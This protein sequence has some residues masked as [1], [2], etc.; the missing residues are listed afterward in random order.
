MRVAILNSS[1]GFGHI[2]AAEAVEETLRERVP[3]VAVEYIDFWS[4]MDDR[5][6]G[7]VRE[8]Y[9]S[10]VTHEP[11][12][13]DHL[14]RF[15]RRQWREFFRSAD[16]PPALAQLFDRAIKRW[17]P[18]SRGFPARGD[19]LDQT[20]LLNMLDTFG[21]AAPAPANLVRRGLV[22]WMHRLLVA[23]LKRQLQRI[24]P[25]LIVATQMMPASLLAAL[26]RRRERDAAPAIGVLTDYGVHDFWLNSN[27]DHYCVATKSMAAELRGRGTEVSSLAVT[28]IPL[29]KGFCK[30]LPQ[31][32]AR[33]RLGSG[34]RSRTVL[35]TGGGY[36]I[37]AA[38][39]LQP[40]LEAGLDCEI[41]VAAGG[42][43][44]DGGHLRAL[45]GRHPAR[46][47][48][49]REHVDMPAM[50]RAADIVVGKPGGLSV[51]EALACG[52]PFLA[53][54]CLGGQESFNVAYLQRNGVGGLVD[55]VGLI[56]Y[57]RSWLSDPLKRS[58]I[59][60]R[61][62]RLGCRNGAE[63]IVDVMINA[64]MRRDRQRKAL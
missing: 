16:M 58:Q 30:P 63:R 31:I 45:A 6:A 17:L 18:D 1:L 35:I 57:L 11:D 37:G 26:K 27:M 14:H 12:I 21:P 59:Q 25:D 23:R 38:H 51:S 8:G 52:R 4:L 60:S 15:D 3:D 29:M 43:Q 13:Y 32:E 61:A 19:N 56:E 44:A 36:G 49:F 54:C 28:G 50:V 7:A 47:H 55:H 34:I 62:W 39:A 2:K 33:A 24:K 41:L 22:I 46:V 53:V 10:L 40:I 64:R 5:V 20:L 42:G 9:L 48:V